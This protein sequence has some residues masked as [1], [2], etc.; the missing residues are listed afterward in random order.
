[1][2]E[3]APQNNPRHFR[4]ISD[5]WFVPL[6]LILLSGGWYSLAPNF[7]WALSGEATAAEAAASMSKEEFERRVHD[8]LIAHPEVIGEA[9]NRL[10]A[11]QR[12]QEAKQG[13]ATLKL[14]ADQVFHDPNDPVSG[15]PQGDATLVE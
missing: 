3:R 11:Q 5:F 10:E 12:E 15:N 4:R 13:Q 6:I 2:T 14:H 7:R 1:M 9:I 8:Y